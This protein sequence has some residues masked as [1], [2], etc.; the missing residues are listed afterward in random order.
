MRKLNIVLAVSIIVLTLSAMLCI[1]RFT[2]CSNKDV[3]YTGLNK[4]EKIKYTTESDFIKCHVNKVDY[5]QNYMEIQTFDFKT[6][7]INF[8][9]NSL[10][11]NRKFNF[12]EGDWVNIIG[13]KSLERNGV[14]FYFL[15][16]RSIIN[17]LAKENDGSK[18]I[19]VPKEEMDVI[20]E[21]NDILE[22]LPSNNVEEN[23]NYGE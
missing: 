11:L 21:T 5:T 4:Q 22:K 12:K 16:N 19:E 13:V 8:L 7:S 10:K 23:Y 2:S 17:S 3:I 20:K 14:K 18:I 15:D 1:S 6:V 9:D